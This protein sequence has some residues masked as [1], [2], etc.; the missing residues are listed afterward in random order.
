[1]IYFINSK[2]R[3]RPKKIEYTRICYTSPLEKLYAIRKINKKQKEAADLFKHIMLGAFSA[4]NCPG[5]SSQ[6]KSIKKNTD[7]SIQLWKKILKSIE[8]NF[9]RAMIDLIKSVIIDETEHLELLE[10]NSILLK[11]K[12]FTGA[13]DLIYQILHTP[14]LHTLIS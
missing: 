13:L 14:E 1:M 3:G 4:I 7:S 9:G 5:L 8:L 11:I 10:T 2:P 12:K 6:S